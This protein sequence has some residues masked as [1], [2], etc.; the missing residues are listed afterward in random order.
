M[1]CSLGILLGTRVLHPELCMHVRTVC[2]G[3]SLGPSH[4][5]TLVSSSNL[6]ELLL[7]MGHTERATKLQAD[8]LAVLGVDVPKEESGGRGASP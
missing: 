7:A 4:V 6:A 1:R 5:D 2:C 3:R 8:M